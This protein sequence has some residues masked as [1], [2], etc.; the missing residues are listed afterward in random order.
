M[1]YLMII[2]LL[3]VLVEQV[4]FQHC[5][6]RGDVVEDDGAVP[7]QHL[8]LLLQHDVLE[9]EQCQLHLSHVDVQVTEGVLVEGGVRAPGGA[10]VPRRPRRGGGGGPRG[11]PASSAPAAATGRTHVGELLQEVLLERART[12]R[13]FTAARLPAR[14]LLDFCNQTPLNLDFALLKIS[15]PLNLENEG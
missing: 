7:G 10:L 5:V 1:I 3:P 15:V 12:T 4:G 9:V 11:R 8:E 6:Y 2:S 13:K 14:P